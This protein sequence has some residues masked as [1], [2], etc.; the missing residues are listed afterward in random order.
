VK[1]EYGAPMVHKPLKDRGVAVGEGQVRKLMQAHGIRSKSKRR[2]KITTDSK[3]NLPTAPSIVDRNFTAT[4]TDQVW[5]ADITYLG[6]GEGWLYFPPEGQD[7]SGQS[8][9]R[10]LMIYSEKA[11]PS[12]Q[13]GSIDL[14]V[15]NKLMALLK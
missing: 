11:K 15:M 5:T 14:A 10:S 8:N 13:D 4:T 2:F 6:L 3:H 1:Q 9:G 12:T 7:K